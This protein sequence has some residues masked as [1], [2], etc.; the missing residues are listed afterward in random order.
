[1]SLEQRETKGKKMDKNY[2]VIVVG[3]GHA[4]VEAALASARMGLKTA[5][6]TI[7]L[8]S[9]AMMSCNPSVGGPGKS[10]LV[11]ELGMLGGE[12]A[13]HIDNYNLQLK[14][15][16]HTKGLASRITRAQADKYW[17]R[18]K[19]REIVENEENLYLVQGIVNDLI[20]ENGSV[21]GL[22]DNLGV[23]YAAKAVVLCTGTFL[24]GQFIMGDVKY[25][26]GRQGE[27]SSDELPDNL[28]KYG[29]ELDRYQ[30][31]T[32]PRVDKKSIDFSKMEELKGEDK[33]RY[34]SYETEKEY[35]QTLPTWLTF[36][37]EKTIET[38]KEMLKYSPIV[39]GV[40]STKGPRH[41]PS[42]DRKIMNFPEKTN[43]QIFLEQE[44]VESNEIY[45][46]GFTTAMPPFAQEAMLKTIAGLENAK[47]VRY[48]YAVE[49]DFIPAYQLN[50]TLETKVVKGLY[51]A[52]TINGTSGYEE[53]ACQGFIAGVNAARKI[54]GKKEIIIERSEGYIGVLID[55]IINKKTPEPYRVLPSRAEYRL[56]LRQDNI[57]IR[58]LEKSKEIG[59]LNSEKL[60]ELENVRNEIEAEIERLKGI[61]VYPTK[62]TNEKLE[63]IGKE[64]NIKN[65]SEDISTK[66]ANNPVSAFE[67]LARKEISY[68]NLSE[69]VETVALSPLAKEQVEINAK[70]NVFIEREKAQI[71]KF[72]KLEKMEIPENI[73]Y[74]KIQGL[75]NIAIS[76]LMY[77]NPATIGQASRISGV[78]YNDIAL[79]IAVIKENHK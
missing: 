70:Y 21:K 17:Y 23:K 47:I 44:S 50:L 27:P 5:L 1:M 42:L 48:G 28:I 52:G 66:S 72:E 46:N 67:F 34:F 36:T 14:N 6:F 43:H 51:T 58:L 18:V 39:T 73:D 79:L 74:E 62:E 25:S 22:I 4:G 41:C 3:A 37:T 78:T 65:G 24:K 69:F 54:L 13:R 75:S 68:D 9:I 61:T 63:R 30:T 45:I 2:D 10:H 16:N 57:F 35:N 38:G 56:T 53:A 31:A 7:Y 32:P 60:K 20:V 29:F 71:E 49:Y 40:V 19:M 77:G 64:F 8:D 76:G 26:A 11:S 33:P 59:L 55:D 15:L 12:M